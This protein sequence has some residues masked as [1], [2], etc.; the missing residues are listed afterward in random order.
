MTFDLNDFESQ[1]ES[2][3]RE[4]STSENLSRAA[5]EFVE[6]SDK[7]MYGYFWTWNGLPIIQMPEDILLTQ[8]IIWNTKPT[9]IIELGVAW[10]GSLALY[11]QLSAAYGGARIIG[12]DLTIPI[13][14][15]IRIKA[16]PFGKNIELHE[17]SSID[18][19]LFS[20]IKES[21]TPEDKV[22]VIIDSNHEHKHVLS[23][24]KMWSRLVTEGNYIVVSDTVVER[25]PAQLH[26]KR[27]W[28]PGNNPETA[29]REFLKENENF[30]R[31]SRYSRKTFASFNPKSYV[32]MSRNR[33]QVDS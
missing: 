7:Y 9:V 26:R 31:D 16:V 17:K 15:E 12:I 28:G 20:I 32:I 19:S 4:A 25:L 14:N 3:V 23:E 8:E 24:L 13:H 1:R 2:W 11:A 27:T 21:L 29:L 6:I 10:G 18:E 33:K 22:M 5:L 30:Y